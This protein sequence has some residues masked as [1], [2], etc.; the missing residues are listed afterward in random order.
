MAALSQ[1]PQCRTGMA[2]MTSGREGAAG[3]PAAPPPRSMLEEAK[4]LKALRC[5][6]RAGALAALVDLRRVHGRQ[7]VLGDDL[8][9]GALV[10][11]VLTGLLPGFDELGVLGHHTDAHELGLIALG[12]RRIADDLERV[13]VVCRHG[14]VFGGRM[15]GEV[16]DGAAT[17]D[18]EESCRLVR[19]RQDGHRRLAGAL[20]L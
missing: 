14:V 15:V 4:L 3:P 18:G 20:E 5:S 1:R 7:S 13:A 11:Q 12:R 8:L 17:G 19:E 9:V 2:L 6:A 10:D 16:S